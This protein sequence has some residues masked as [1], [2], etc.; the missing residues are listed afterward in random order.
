MNAILIIG[1]LDNCHVDET[2]NNIP[3]L[4]P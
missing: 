4:T 1:L 3:N 2:M